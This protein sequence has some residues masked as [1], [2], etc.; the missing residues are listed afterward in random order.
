MAGKNTIR[1][2]PTQKIPTSSV[3]E[4]QS[5]EALLS[6]DHATDTAKVLPG[7][8]HFFASEEKYRRKYEATKAE[9]LKAKKHILLLEEGEVKEAVPAEEEGELDNLK[10]EIA[11]LKAKIEDQQENAD[12]SWAL[13]GECYA[14]VKTMRK[15]HRSD[16]NAFND[17]TMALAAETAKLAKEQIEFTQEKLKF[18]KKSQKD[19]VAYVEAEA[20]RLEAKNFTLKSEL[21]AK[22]AR[23]RA[24][25][26]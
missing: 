25:E 26:E 11:S 4:T 15:L 23:T 21:E 20:N 24:I 19:K 7:P 3:K 13:L 5:R 16:A 12:L 6:E 10:A 22:V 17:E 8:F 2:T 1:Q 14:E 9:L 18:S